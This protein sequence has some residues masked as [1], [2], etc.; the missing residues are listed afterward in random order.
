MLKL[1]RFVVAAGILLA[2]GAA[3][4]TECSSAISQYNF[5]IGLGFPENA[6]EVL[7]SHPECF[8]SSSNTAAASLAIQSTTLGQMQTVSSALGSRFGQVS[9]PPGRVADAGGIR[10][11]AAGN[12]PGKW[13]AWASVSENDVRYDRG[14]FFFNAAN[15]TNKF[16]SRIRNLVVGGD[17]QWAPNLAFGVSGAFDESRGS[18]ES[19]AIA[20]PT[21]PKSVT[22]NGYSIAPYIG[23]QFAKDWAMDATIGWGEGE[24][25]VDGAVTTD[26]KRFFYGANVGYTTWQGNWQLTGK[27]SYLFGQEKS[28]DSKNNGVTLA[29]SKVTNEVGQ[30]RVGGQAAYWMDGVMPYVGLTYAVDRLS[31]TATAAQRNATEMGKSAWIWSLGANFVSIKNAITGGIGYEY[32]TARSRS[33]NSKLMANINL[34]F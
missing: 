27:G 7:A 18:T 6:A 11:V 24:S 32:E 8:G 29:N 13:N 20:A 21:A 31:G 23:W 9:A 5:Y 12:P 3:S 17:Y 15:R 19:Y 25:T 28:D 16:D 33:K 30:F 4:A 22:G 1:Q 2:S 10:G 34:R 14:V 26:S